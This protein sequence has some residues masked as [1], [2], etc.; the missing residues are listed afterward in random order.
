[1]PSTESR[2]QTLRVL[3]FRM[4]PKLPKLLKRWRP[5]V[6]PWLEMLRP[7]LQQL[8]GRQRL[9]LQGVPASYND[10]MGNACRKWRE[11]PLK[12]KGGL[13]VFSNCLWSSAMGL[14][15]QSTWGTHVPSTIIDGEHVFGSSWPYPLS[16]P[17]PQGNLSLKLPTH[18]CWQPLHQNGNAIHSGRRLQDQLLLLKSL[19]VKSKERGNFLQGLKRTTRRPFARILI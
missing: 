19:L 1:M 16:H 2:Y 6:H 12:R 8:S 14:S 5:I 17:L 3:S 9:P 15:T 11:R 4:R 10:C 13:P 7:C 18:L